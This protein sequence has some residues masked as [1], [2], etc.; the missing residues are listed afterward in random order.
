MTS[1]VFMGTPHFAVPI[2]QALI[3][4]DDYQVLAVVTQ[5]DRRVGRK[6][7]LKATPVKEAALSNGIEV[8]TPEKINH[9]PEMDR[10]IELAPDL[11]ITAAFGQFLPERLLAAAKLAAIN[12]HGS[13]LPKYRGGA[14]IQYAVMN[15]DKETG[16]TIM[17][18][19]KKMDAGDIISQAHLEITPQDDTGT[20]F[21]KLSLLGRD[22]LLETL[23]KLIAGTITP[24]KQDESGVVFSPNITREQEQID[25]TL[26]AERID[27]LVRGLRPAP[28]G[29]MVLD[30]LVTKIYDVT[31]L[32]ETTD[33]KPGQVV[34]VEKHALILAAGEGTTYQINS[35]KPAGKPKMD[36][37]AYLN[38]H[39]NL[40][41]GVQAISHE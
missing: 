31:P 41:A 37:T 4:S 34:R 26:P 38:G 20:M 21:E 1:I 6:H 22:L 23:P 14:P 8:L 18:M 17:Y 40:R 12:V 19:V 33:L 16:V 28:V 3:E 36:I 24:V 2:L 27:D 9:S 32:E 7:Q 35:L 39:Q 15:G 30:G 10:V 11:I 5:P 29:N 25:Y 13:L